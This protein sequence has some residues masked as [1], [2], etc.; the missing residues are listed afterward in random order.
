MLTKV[1]ES[2]ASGINGIEWD[3]VEFP[4]QF[5]E[6]FCYDPKVMATMT[7]HIKTGEPLPHDIF[8]QLCSARKYMA[9]SGLLRQLYFSM[10]DLQLHEHT[11]SRSVEE[12]QEALVP[13][14]TVIPPLATD[15]FLCSF[16]H[17]FAGG[18]AAG[19]YSYKWAEVLAA[20][21]FEAFEEQDGE[22]GEEKKKELGLRFRNT[23][24]ALGGST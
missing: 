6:G 17:I 1:N 15:R 7:G 19:Y 4:S 16:S 18:Y 21:A 10:L 12:I 20:D 3:A 9:A 11:S 22:Q 23:V 13:D 24:L 14:Y 5:M 2:Q 8:Q